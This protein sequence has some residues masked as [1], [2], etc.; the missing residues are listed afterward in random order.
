[1]S[2]KYTADNFLAVAQIRPLT[3]GSLHRTAMHSIVTRG[4]GG[5]G[6]ARCGHSELVIWNMSKGVISLLVP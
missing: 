3:E 5:E 6:L 2:I 1:M 4:V